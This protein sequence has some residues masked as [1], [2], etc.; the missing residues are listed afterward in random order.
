MRVAIT[1]SSGL[2]GTAL[3]THLTTLGHTPVPMVRGEP[4]AGEIGWSPNDDKAESAALAADL[5]GID[6]VV[7]LAGAGIGDKRWTDEYKRILVESR[8]KGTTLLAAAVARCEN[9]PKVLL[10]G[11][12]IGIYGARG[13]EELDETS[14]PGTGFLADLTVQWEQC[15]AAASA[16]GVRVVLLRTGIVLSKH[17]GAL[18]KQLPLF[19]VGAGGTIGSGDQWQSWISIDDEVAAIAHLLTADIDGPVN[20]TAPNPVTQA[21]FADTL[22]KVLKRPTFL[23]IPK[24]GP[25]LLLG[26]ELAENLLFTG[27]RVHPAVLLGD[28]T[29]TFQHSELEAALRAVLGR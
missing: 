25:K 9:G 27:Q 4:N 11:S 12:A 19:K 2:V 8:T 5:E 28:S 24:F 7:H 23:P 15:T 3:K 13:D 20:L 6:A 10:S 21:D 17:G 26:S 1:G 14:A 29:F 18:K 22:G 16:A